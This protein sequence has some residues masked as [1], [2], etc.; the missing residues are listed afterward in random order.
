MF[1]SGAAAITAGI[2]ADA[3]YDRYY[4]KPLWIIGAFIELGGVMNLLRSGTFESLAS[5]SEKYNADQLRQ[6]WSE[7]ALATR[8]GRKI[9]GVASF[10]LGALTVG[11][12][13][14]I[15]AGLGK[16]EKDR[17]QD[18]AIAL[19]ATG[20]GIIGSGFVS[21]L[22]ESPLESGYRAAYG[23]DPDANS[24]LKF[25]IAPTLGGATMHLRASF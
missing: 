13:A 21:L 4:G 12:G 18:W 2:I 14:A 23:T 17:K 5:A 3:V 7:R 15:A 6:E 25:D 16:L 19:I 24:S 11:T 20:G 22:V 1:I 8:K 9:G 10:V